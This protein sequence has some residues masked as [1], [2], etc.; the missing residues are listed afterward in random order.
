MTAGKEEWNSMRE[1]ISAFLFKFCTV[2]FNNQRKLELKNKKIKKK[3]F[4]LRVKIKPFQQKQPFL[5]KERPKFISFVCFICLFHGIHQ[6]NTTLRYSLNT[7]LTFGI[8]PAS[9]ELV[10][11]KEIYMLQSP[12]FWLVK[13]NLNSECCFLPDV[14]QPW[15]TQ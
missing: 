2:V 14:T 10:I 3:C 7:M 12:L 1:L 5:R 9:A 13:I 15:S 4:L 6:A 11:I 8:H